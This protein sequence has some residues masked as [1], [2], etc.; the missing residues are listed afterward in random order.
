VARRRASQ[1]AITSAPLPGPSGTTMR[2]GASARA[3]LGVPRLN[4][5][6]VGKV[7]R[8]VNNQRRW[9]IAHLQSGGIHKA[10]RCHWTR[11]NPVSACR[12]GDESRENA[13]VLIG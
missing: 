11:C 7:Q 12:W 3:G 13:A 4:A 9:V 2:S 5:A 1:R 10:L 8:A 6:R